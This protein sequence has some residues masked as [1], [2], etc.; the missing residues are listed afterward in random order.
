MMSTVSL[1]VRK[2]TPGHSLAISNQLKQALE[3][4]PN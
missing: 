2:L 4:L 1:V 3:G